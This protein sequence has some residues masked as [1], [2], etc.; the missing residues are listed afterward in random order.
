MPRNSFAAELLGTFLLT[1]VVWYSVALAMPISAPVMAAL[2]LGLFVCLIGD[3]SGAHLNPAVSVGLWS[4]G[5]LTAKDTLLHVIAQFA[6]ALL[7]MFFAEAVAGQSAPLDQTNDLLVG[8]AEA[9]GAFVL[10]FGVAS[11][12]YKRTEKNLAGMVVGLSLLLGLFIA[13]PFSNDILNPAVALGIGSF[14]VMYALGPVVGAVAGAWAYRWI[15]G[16]K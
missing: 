5:K 11:V 4:I 2:T 7:A 6:G 1:L 15:V 8:L 16:V 10:A 12:V 14:G 9:M 3:V 13:S